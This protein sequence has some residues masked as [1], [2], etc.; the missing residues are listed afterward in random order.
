MKIYATRDHRGGTHAVMVSRHGETYEARWRGT[1]PPTPDWT[2]QSP[3][4]SDDNLDHDVRI[5]HC[6]AR[7]MGHIYDLP[8][9]DLLDR[10]GEVVEVPIRWWLADEDFGPWRDDVSP[11]DGLPG[12]ASYDEAYEAGVQAWRDAWDG[13]QWDG[14]PLIVDTPGEEICPDLPQEEESK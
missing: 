2:I 4:R 9:A 14:L 11:S 5:R 7:A 13:D 6:L 3:V 10:M 8:L 12:Y 1:M